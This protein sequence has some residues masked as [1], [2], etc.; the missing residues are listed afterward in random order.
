MKQIIELPLYEPKVK[1][2]LHHAYQFAITGK[3][4]KTK[5]SWFY[6][7]YIHLVCEYYFLQFYMPDQDGDNWGIKNPFIEREVISRRFILDNNIDLIEMIRNELNSGRYIVSYVNE[8][9]ILGSYANLNNEN[10]NHMIMIHGYDTS[11]EIFLYSSF[12]KDRSFHR[13]E[14]PFSKFSASYFDNEYDYENTESRMQFLKLQREEINFTFDLSTYIRSLYIYRDSLPPDNNIFQQK[15]SK[16]EISFGLNT[17]DSVASYLAQFTNGDDSIIFNNL[18]IS[19]HLLVEHKELLIECLEYIV[20]F[21]GKKIAHYIQRYEELYNGFLLLRNKMLKFYV[22]KDIRC[23][24]GIERGLLELKNNEYSL[25]TAII[26]E[27]Q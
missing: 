27:L 16:I 24:V 25:L 7:N 12:N 19:I 15:K 21:S 18:M 10:F 8:K 9:Y 20:S 6:M 1:S 17:Y 3:D 4:Q 14:V 22:S 26:L 23:L 5:A 2:Y 13:G 11:K